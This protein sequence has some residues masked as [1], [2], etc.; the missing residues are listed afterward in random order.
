MKQQQ[1]LLDLI[2]H[3]KL[4]KCSFYFKEI[5]FDNFQLDCMAPHPR[6]LFLLR[7]AHRSRRI[8]QGQRDPMVGGSHPLPLVRRLR[9]LHE[10]QRAN[11]RRAQ[12]AL[13]ATTKCKLII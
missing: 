12:E 1:Q 2:P 10:V 13:Q 11:G 6:R 7:L 8:L 9:Q 4:R 5:F 3:K